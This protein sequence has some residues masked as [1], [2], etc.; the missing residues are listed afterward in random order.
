MR[1]LSPL[2]VELAAGHRASSAMAKYS[3]SNTFKRS[4]CCFGTIPAGPINHKAIAPGRAI[5][6]TAGG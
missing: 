5:P 4:L 2:F 6:K 1:D 3:D